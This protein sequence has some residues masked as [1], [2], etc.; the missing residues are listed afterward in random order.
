MSWPR[1]TST[2]GGGC[3]QRRVLT[4]ERDI[5]HAVMDMRVFP[6]AGGDVKHLPV[7]EHVLFQGSNSRLG[8]GAV[9]VRDRQLANLWRV[10]CPANERENG[11]GDGETSR[12]GSVGE[13]RRGESK[14]HLT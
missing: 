1:R 13:L 9:D 5:P 3:G 10:I 8:R 6:V 2:S 11:L 7:W 14:R 12:A 4:V